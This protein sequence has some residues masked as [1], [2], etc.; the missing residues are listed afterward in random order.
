M[1]AEISGD[2]A[3]PGYG[4]ATVAL[5]PSKTARSR[6]TTAGA[7]LKDVQVVQAL[8]MVVVGDG[9]NPGATARSG[10]FGAEM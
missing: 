8:S 6:L 1:V 4:I 3:T 5:R 10:V 2:A 7:F 9:A